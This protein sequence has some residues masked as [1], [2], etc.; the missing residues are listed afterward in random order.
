[1]KN[2]DKYIETLPD[3]LDSK[4]VISLYQLIKKNCPVTISKINN[5]IYG[6]SYF[7]FR[8]KDR[9]AWWKS[10]IFDKAKRILWG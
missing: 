2:F 4:K 7:S 3:K 10:R 9:G 8:K 1:M 6:K 5:K